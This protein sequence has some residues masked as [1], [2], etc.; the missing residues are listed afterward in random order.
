M[1][2]RMIFTKM[3]IYYI[4]SF[5]VVSVRRTIRKKSLKESVEI[6]FCTVSMLRTP[7]GK[8]LRRPLN[9]IPIFSIRF[10]ASPSRNHYSTHTAPHGSAMFR[11]EARS[12]QPLD[13]V[14]FTQVE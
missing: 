10:S 14:A 1:K 9:V 11:R 8:K 6:T 12:R 7:P 5:P 2:R 13:E 4:I 3:N